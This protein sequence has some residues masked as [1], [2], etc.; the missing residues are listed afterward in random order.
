MKETERQ[1]LVVMKLTELVIHLA[2]SAA[3]RRL[4]LGK[5]EELKTLRGREVLDPSVQEWKDLAKDAVDM[6]IEYTKQLNFC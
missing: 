6:Y 1:K 4:A 5:L 2:Q 3:V